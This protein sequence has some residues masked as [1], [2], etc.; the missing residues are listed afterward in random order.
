MFDRTDKSAPVLVTGVGGFIGSAIATRLVKDGFQVVGVDDFSNGYVENVPEG[1]D[2]IQA[3]LTCP[4]IASLLPSKV[5]SILHIAGQSSG[6][7]SFQD[8]VVDLNSNVVSTLNLI[9]YGS[10]LNARRIVYASSMTVYGAQSDIPCGEESEC[11]PLSCYGIGKRAA[12][13]YLQLHEDKLPWVSFRIFNVY[14]PGQNLKDIRQGMVSIFLSQALECG[15]VQVEGALE[16]FRDFIFIDDVVQAFRLTLNE[17]SPSNTVMNLGSGT[18]TT[19]EQLLQ[20]LKVHIPGLTWHTAGGTPG[21]QHGIY[22]D[23]QLAQE[24][25]NLGKPISLS[26]GLESFVNW[27][28]SAKRSGP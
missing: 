12:E 5:H 4:S 6:E 20:A 17:N 22:A 14:G 1:V 9:R 24:T 16:R 2:L 11:N 18:R 28:Q 25:L 13:R 8:P 23:A 15:H 10:E 27:A 19:V 3:D 21:D 26:D 7:R